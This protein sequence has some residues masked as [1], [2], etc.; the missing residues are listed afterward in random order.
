MVISRRETPDDPG[1]GFW[2]AEVEQT[3]LLL[4][5]MTLPPHVTLWCS[6]GVSQIQI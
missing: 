6:L 2:A 5:D 1:P 4:Y 3:L